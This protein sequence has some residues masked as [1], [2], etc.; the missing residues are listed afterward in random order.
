MIRRALCAVLFLCS[1]AFAQATPLVSPNEIVYRDLE[2]LAA[3]GLVDSLIIGIRPISE[4]Q[5]LSLLR[6]ARANLDRNPSARAWA[7]PVITADLARYERPRQRWIDSWLNE[8]SVMRSPP[9][10]APSD[11]NGSIDYDIKPFAMNRAGRPL[12]DGST[13]LIESSHVAMLGRYLAFTAAPRIALTSRDVSTNSSLRLQRAT[14]TAMLGG[15]AIDV[16]RDEQLFG[17]SPTGGL[18]LSANAPSLDMI[19]IRNDHEWNIPLL[20]YVFGGIRG[21]LMVSDLGRDRVKYPHTKLIGWRLAATPHPQFEI[22]VGV[23]DEMGGDGGQEATFWDRVLDILPVV[24]AFRTDNDFLF[25]N[26]LAGFDLRWRMPKW[27]GFDMYAEMAADDI[28]GRTIRRAIHEDAAYLVGASL[29]CFIQCGRYGVRVEYR[30]TGTRFY[31][32]TEYPLAR[33]GLVFGDP[34]GPRGMGGYLTLDADAARAGT[35]ALNAA[36]EARSGNTYGARG[37]GPNEEEFHFELL[38]RRPSE[39]RGRLLA[40]WASN[41]RV[42]V[43]YFVGAGVELVDNFA[44]TQN[45]SRVNWLAR[46]GMSVHPR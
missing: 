35:F 21:T 20:S 41:E 13:A 44:F 42:P 4:R 3:L 6:E 45:A 1:N 2:R 37:G 9:R 27:A 10:P 7:E 40:S 24:D 43:S 26:K 38:S 23:L 15:L 31:T 8:G 5:V 18:M 39:K 19:R 28:E 11:P 22:G 29:S 46:F 36:F 14:V 16:G 32:H 34:L 17:P 12:I 25:S 33:S 30:Q